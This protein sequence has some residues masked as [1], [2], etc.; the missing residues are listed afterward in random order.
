MGILF[1]SFSQSYAGKEKILSQLKVSDFF[2]SG[3]EKNR[4]KEE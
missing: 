2:F 4:M 1:F 3:C